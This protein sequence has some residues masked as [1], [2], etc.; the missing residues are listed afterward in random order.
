LQQVIAA[1]RHAS[2][3]NRTFRIRQPQGEK[4]AADEAAFPLM[5]VAC[6]V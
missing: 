1:L 6:A 3:Y 2:N 5:L 4:K